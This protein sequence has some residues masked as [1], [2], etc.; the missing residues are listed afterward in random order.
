MKLGI[1]LVIIGIL[2][3]IGYLAGGE[4]NDPIGLA[5]GALLFIWG[6]SRMEKARKAKRESEAKYDEK[7]H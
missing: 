6:S 7:A 1:A 2:F 4:G 3:I 5:A